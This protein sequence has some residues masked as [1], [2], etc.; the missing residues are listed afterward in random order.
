VGP[1][2][3]PVATR[4]GRVDANGASRAAS[5]RDTPGEYDG[6]E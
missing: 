1:H 4:T 6:G 2:L 3:D 5:S